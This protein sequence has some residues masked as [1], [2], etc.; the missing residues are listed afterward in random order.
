MSDKPLKF[1][2]SALTAENVLAV[3]RRC[4]PNTAKDIARGTAVENGGHRIKMFAINRVFR[5][6]LKDEFNASTANGRFA[7]I[8]IPSNKTRPHYRLDSP[9]LP[10]AAWIC[11]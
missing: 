6:Y 8:V 11:G 5:G 4:G 2:S 3:L 9:P 1:D 10:G 7:L